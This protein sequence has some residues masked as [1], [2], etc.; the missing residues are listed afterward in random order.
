MI[1]TLLF[2]IQKKE[3]LRERRIAEI[4]LGNRISSGYD[5]MGENVLL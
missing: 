2:F 3:V 5:F 4:P 1:L